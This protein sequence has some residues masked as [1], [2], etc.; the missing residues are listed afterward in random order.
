LPPGVSPGRRRLDRSW[1]I[2]AGQAAGRRYVPAVPHTPSAKKR[3]P[4]G[5]HRL[6]SPLKSQVLVS[7]RDL[8]R[9]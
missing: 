9:P 7:G 1:P 4:S 3:G 2:A 8:R 6:G 5:R